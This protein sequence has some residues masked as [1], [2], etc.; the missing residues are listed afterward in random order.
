MILSTSEAN[1]SRSLSDLQNV[2]KHKER[3]LNDNEFPLLTLLNRQDS[4]K[5]NF[6]V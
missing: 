2:E 6:F 4:G 3:Y 5:Q 1:L